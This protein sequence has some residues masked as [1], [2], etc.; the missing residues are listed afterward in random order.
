MIKEKS[1]Q[2]KMR[3][4]A[5]ILKKLVR[6]E[7]QRLNEGPVTMVM[8][9]MY[10]SSIKRRQERAASQ[11]EKTSAGSELVKNVSQEEFLQKQKTIVTAALILHVVATII[12]HTMMENIMPD[13]MSYGNIGDGT[14]SLTKDKVIDAFYAMDPSEAQSII[15]QLGEGN[16]SAEEILSVDKAELIDIIK[17]YNPIGFYQQNA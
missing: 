15:D 6:E 13:Q 7:F 4:T 2:S 9:M 11:R 5:Q 1:R 10:I 17:K 3:L 12:G 14:T 16:F 8:L